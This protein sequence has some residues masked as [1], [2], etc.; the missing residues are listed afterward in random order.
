MTLPVFI[1]NIAVNQAPLSPRPGL[2]P[3]AGGL[4]SV[5]P[6]A[7]PQEEAEAAAGHPHFSDPASLTQSQSQQPLPGGPDPCPLDG[8]PAS[9]PLPPALCISTGATVPYFA[10]GSG[11]AVPTIGTLILPPEYSSW[12]HPYG[13]LGPGAWLGEVCHQPLTD[14]A[15]SAEA[16]PS[17]EQSCGGADPG[18]TPGS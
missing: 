17:Y 18:L 8:S 15:L 2:G 1:G 6:S 13:K 9:H 11:G 4:P 7:P 12:G 14:F 5:V 16:P 3:P 10:E